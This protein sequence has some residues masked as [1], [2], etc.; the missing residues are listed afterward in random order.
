METGHG[1]RTYGYKQ[2]SGSV[3]KTV[4]TNTSA[5]PKATGKCYTD[6][7]IKFRANVKGMGPSR[8][9]GSK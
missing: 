7:A 9:T 8:K 6:S 4:P 2:G 3:G 5:G 1:K